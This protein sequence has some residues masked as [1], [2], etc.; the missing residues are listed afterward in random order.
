MKHQQGF[1][2][3]EVLVAF[4]VAAMALGM[5]FGLSAASK[6][7]AFTALAQIDH[8]LYARAALNAA[9]VEPEPDYPEFPATYADDYK[10]E[11]GELLERPERETANILYALEPYQLESTKAGGASVTAW[12][13]KKLDKVRPR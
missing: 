7:L 4:T 5:V 13:W 9:Q 3:L 6:R 8:A 2:L 10:L 1:T 12:R 11:P